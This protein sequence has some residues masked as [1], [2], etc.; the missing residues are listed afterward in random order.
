MEA[1]QAQHYPNLV[2]VVLDNASTD[3]T[4]DIIA[5]YANDRVPLKTARND[6]ILPLSQNWNAAVGLIPPS[7]TYFRMLSADDTIRPD[8]VQLTVE[9]A[10]R[11]PN[12]GVVGC[13]FHENDGPTV[14]SSWPSDRN[15]FS[16]REA[17]QLYFRTISSCWLPTAHALYRCDELKRHEPYFH[18]LLIANDLAATMNVLSHRDMGFVHADLAMTRLHVK[19]ITSTALVLEERHTYEWLYFLEY[20]APFGLGDDMAAE[21]SQLYRRHYLR[22]LLKSRFDV[23]RRQLY[24]LHMEGLE[25]IGMRPSAANFLD[26]LLD[27]PLVR[28]GRRRVWPDHPFRLETC[29]P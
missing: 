24:R 23:K 20:Y 15:V 14:E 17:V 13:L 8:Y 16:G 1:V 12:V 22:Q 26:A 9:V 4:P 27:W 21:F 7:A 6:A 28:M 29:A 2:H 11:Y 19:N 10:E 5:S 25:R 3:D 18:E